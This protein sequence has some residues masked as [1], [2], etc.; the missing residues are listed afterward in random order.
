MKQMETLNV[1]NLE[2][3]QF[4]GQT[5]TIND[6]KVTEMMEA[7][8]SH[9]RTYAL[10][11]LV[12][13]HCHIQPA[14]A[15]LFTAAGV[16]SV[17][18][19]AGNSLHLKPLKDH[20]YASFDPTIFTA[21]R[22]IDGVPGL[23]GK[24]SSGSFSTQS[25]HD[26]IEEVKR[27][28]DVGASFIKVYGQLKRDVME[29]VVNEAAKY[30]LDISADLLAS[31]DVDAR[32]AAKMGIRFLEHNSGIIQSLVPN[33]HCLLS[34]KEDRALL[35]KGL[36]EDK[37]STLCEE[38]IT[39]GVVVVPTLSLF[40]Q[41][42]KE[43]HWSISTSVKTS[44][45]TSLEEHWNYVR[46][47]IQSSKQTRLLEVNKQ[48][49]TA[50]H[51]K[52]GTILAGTDSP[53]GVDTYPGQLL[54]RELQLLVQCGL[55]PFEAIQSAT[56]I[57]SKLFGLNSVCKVG[58][59]ADLVILKSNPLKDIS[60]TRLIEWV[61]KNGMWHRPEALIAKAEQNQQTY[62]QASYD[63]QEQ[64]YYDYMNKQYPHLMK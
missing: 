29:A 17:R 57:P 4:E 18:N 44:A 13:N 59:Q 38:L 40:A 56:S 1:L 22:M 28:V 15:P 49:T 11:G 34:E 25:K 32:T 31:T 48:I 30:K 54:H 27:Q 19:T 61:V 45:L 9:L 42:T 39:A 47:Y 21:D 51:E 26:A 64:V 62:N 6:G 23:W 24:T 46:P 55:S 43:S 8:I 10:P 3:G 12:D 36:D 35:E 2:T 5:I 52:G 37:L 16:T 7:P 41:G 60:A 63:K 14:Y 50:Y 33:W 58:G 53:A 20:Q